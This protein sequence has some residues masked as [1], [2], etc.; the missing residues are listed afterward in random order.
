[1]AGIDSY[2]ES[3]TIEELDQDPYPVWKRLRH[4]APLAWIPAADSWFITRFDDVAAALRGDHG[5][6][7]AT[8]HPTMNQVFGQP[9]ILTSTGPEHDDIRDGVDKTLQPDPVM[10][11]IDDIVRPVARHYLQQVA[12][13]GRAELVTEFFE[14]VSVEALR[15]VMGLDTVADTETIRRWFT[16]LNIGVS[17]FG[18]D[19]ELYAVAD[20]ASSEFEAAVS[21]LLEEL[22]HNP[23]HSMI[24]H[25]LWAGREGTTPRPA[26]QILPSLKVILLGGMQE[27]GHAAASSL[28]GLFT[29]PDQWRMLV[30]DPDEWVPLAVQEGLRWIA[31]ISVTDRQTTRT[32][33][34][35]GKTLPAGMPVQV[36]LA[37]ANRDE[38]NFPDPDV[39]DIDRANRAHQAF[40][41]GEHFCAGHFFGRQVERIMFEELVK[42][43]PD[44]AA[45]STEEPE[46]N[47]WVFRA[48]K[49]LP[50]VFTP[51]AGRERSTVR[52]SI[53]VGELR[54]SGFA[55]HGVAELV[56][57]AMRLEAEGILSV[58]LRD[59]NG[60][61]LPNWEPGAHI[62]LWSSAEHFSKYSLCADPAERRSWR[63]GVAREETSRGTSRLVHESLRPGMRVRVG[64]PVNNFTLQPAK[65]YLFV[66]GGIGVTPLLPMMAEA[67]RNGV[68]FTV[69]YC[70]KSRRR[71]PFLAELEK[72]G[73]RVQLFVGDEGARLN[74]TAAVAEAVSAESAIYCCGPDRLMDQAQ[75]IAEEH[76][77]EVRCERFTGVEALRDGDT[78]FTVR[79]GRDGKTVI[80]P[81]DKTAL[82]VLAEEGMQVLNSCQ[83]GNCGSC[84]TR[85]LDG[86]PE[87]RDV[88][89]TKGQKARNDRMMICVSRGGDETIVLDV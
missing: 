21:P 59:P 2:L 65:S 38:R 27:P 47:G 83:A 40:G 49:K 26:S 12:G 13:R 1:M 41:G 60:S 11:M 56:V 81:A 70:G 78:P 36:V 79:L 55:E 24:S 8:N 37:S 23:D 74:L 57:S 9:S 19:P 39:F 48:P 44:V 82:Q 68:E 3:I 20:Q 17:N 18:Q 88:Y 45:S 10:A 7:G 52:E 46:V 62:D 86:T 34:L 80:V 35:H 25:M 29:R 33:T 30:E 54:Q 67:D 84:E 69:L 5:F 73:E 14:P 16:Q 58:E 15:R 61:P 42:V 28:H 32:T 64:A 53:N 50:V 89:L 85:I 76:A 87:H 66:A 22:A 72:Y 71:M 51:T 43:M 4:E 75:R 6:G 63:I 31:P 77:I